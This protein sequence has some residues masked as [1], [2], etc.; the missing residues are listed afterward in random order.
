LACGFPLLFKRSFFFFCE[1][2]CSPSCP[3]FFRR[4]PPCPLS[5]RPTVALPRR[6]PFPPPPCGAVFVENP[7]ATALLR[8]TQLPSSAPR[9][10]FLPRRTV[11][12]LSG[13]G[14][15]RTTFG[16]SSRLGVDGHEPSP[17]T[18]HKALSTS[19]FCV[20]PKHLLALAV[21]FFP[22][23]MKCKIGLLFSPVFSPRSGP[24]PDRAD[25]YTGNLL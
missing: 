10:C 6:P 21:S 15:S 7:F 2:L 16:L 22:D 19:F 9:N 17:S 4:L 1:K 11:F 13:G 12:A 20:W 25:L 3:P 23:P 18:G 5:R 24:C 8:G 14:F